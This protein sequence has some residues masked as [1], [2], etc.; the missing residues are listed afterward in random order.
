[1]SFDGHIFILSTLAVESF[2]HLGRNGEVLLEKVAI[3][4]VEGEEGGGETRKGAYGAYQA[5]DIGHSAGGHL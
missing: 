5:S 3:S 2:E 1:M 4:V